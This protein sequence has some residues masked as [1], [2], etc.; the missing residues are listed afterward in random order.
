M[1]LAA[2]QV[3]N[4][5]TI[6]TFRLRHIDQLPRL[7][8]GVVMMCKELGMIG[9]EHMAVDGQ[10]IHANADYRRSK[11]LKGVRAEYAKLK[12]GLDRLLNK[13]IGEYVNQGTIDRRADRLK[14][15]LDRLTRLQEELEKL[16]D[17][18]ARVNMTDGEAP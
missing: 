8:A 4:F 14:R 5:R 6:N 16:G 15:K 3:P 10:K 11:N 12:E 9:F 7:F 13:D 1:Y 18:D 17:E 2:G